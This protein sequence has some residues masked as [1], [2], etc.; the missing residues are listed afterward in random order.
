ME[1][2]KEQETW[3]RVE[4]GC[5]ELEERMRDTDPEAGTASRATELHYLARCWVF[6]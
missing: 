1:K 6:G 4:M 5:V 3:L 2:L